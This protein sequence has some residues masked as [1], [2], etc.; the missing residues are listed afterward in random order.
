[1][2][3]LKS[4]LICRVKNYTQ[5]GNAQVELLSSRNS[6]DFGKESR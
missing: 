2:N 4:F 3:L 6:F 1:M 5:E